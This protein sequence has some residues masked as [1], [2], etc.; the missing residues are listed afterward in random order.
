MARASSRSFGNSARI[1]PRTCGNR[2]AAADPC[3]TRAITRWVGDVA[4]P[5]TRLA[6]EKP[7]MPIR[8]QRLRPYRSPSRPPVIRKTPYPQA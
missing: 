1:D 5:Q 2:T 4:R 6:S 8:K 7:A 3:T